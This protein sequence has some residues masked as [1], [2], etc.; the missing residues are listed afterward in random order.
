MLRFT[1][2]GERIRK[3]TIDFRRSSMCM[4]SLGFR[5]VFHGR[6]RVV[7][8]RDGLDGDDCA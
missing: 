2:R 4:R 1:R 6:E 8:T 3:S 7:G 5:L